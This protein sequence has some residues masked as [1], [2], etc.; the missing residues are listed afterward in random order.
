MCRQP[1]RRCPRTRSPHLRSQTGLWTPLQ[2]P[3]PRP[4]S[5]HPPHRHLPRQHPRQR[6]SPPRRPPPQ[7]LM[8]RHQWLRRSTLSTLHGKRPRLWWRWP[9]LWPRRPP[10]RS[11]CRRSSSNRRKIAPPPSGPPGSRRPLPRPPPP[12]LPQ[13]RPPPRQ[14]RASRPRLGC[15]TGRRGCWQA[16]RTLRSRPRPKPRAAVRWCR[17]PRLFRIGPRSMWLALNEWPAALVSR[18]L[19][20]WLGSCV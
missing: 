4:P 18:A 12:L 2:S 5:Q 8:L 6:H 11:G 15:R 14:T 1:P 20:K 9:Q 19:C 7:C 10:C 13:R 17:A 3:P 16:R